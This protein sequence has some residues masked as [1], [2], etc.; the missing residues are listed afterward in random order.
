MLKIR[1]NLKIY[2]YSYPTDMRKSINGLAALVI[3]ELELN[4]SNGAG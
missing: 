4:P 3:D 2:L 1:D